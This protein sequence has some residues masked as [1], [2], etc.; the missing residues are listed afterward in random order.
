MYDFYRCR[1]YA[2]RRYVLEIHVVR[3]LGDRLP[4]LFIYLQRLPNSPRS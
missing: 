1:T 3:E 2:W 4:S